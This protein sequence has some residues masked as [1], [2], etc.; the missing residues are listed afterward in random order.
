MADVHF[1]PLK[2]KNFDLLPGFI[3]IPSAIIGVKFLQKL[4][5][6]FRTALED[7][8]DG[9]GSCLASTESYPPKLLSDLAL[10]W[11]VCAVVY[12]SHSQPAQL[13]RT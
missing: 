7:K 8:T 11:E 5:G 1:L 9:K 3:P 6:S 13:N 2:L 10:P 12:S 4:P